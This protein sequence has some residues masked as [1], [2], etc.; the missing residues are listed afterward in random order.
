MYVWLWRR[1]PGGL[2]GKIVSSLVLAA[3]VVALLFFVVFPRVE[4]WMPWNHVTVT[5]A[6]AAAGSTPAG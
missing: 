6:P 5:P 1:F 4:G 3:A 2:P